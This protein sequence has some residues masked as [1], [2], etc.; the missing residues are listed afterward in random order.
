MDLRLEHVER[1]RAATLRA[2]ERLDVDALDA[3]LASDPLAPL[4]DARQLAHL[5][6]RR[7]AAVERIERSVAQHGRA[8]ALPW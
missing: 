4:L 8:L 2:L 3:R 7:V 5:E 6:E 1:F